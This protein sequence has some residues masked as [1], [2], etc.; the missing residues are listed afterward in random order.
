V[1]PGSGEAGMIATSGSIPLGY[2]KDEERTA[3]TFPTI[4]GVTIPASDRPGP[5]S[6]QSPSKPCLRG[7]HS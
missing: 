2:Y 4:D 1:V 3:K 5:L 6:L 7:I